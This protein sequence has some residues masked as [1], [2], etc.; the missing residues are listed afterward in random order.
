MRQRASG[1]LGALM[2]EWRH[3]TQRASLALCAPTSNSS[4]AYSVVAARPRRPSPVSPS[5]RRRAVKGPALPSDEVGVRAATWTSLCTHVPWEGWVTWVG[6]LT[7]WSPQPTNVSLQHYKGLHAPN[8]HPTQRP[9][10]QSRGLVQKRLGSYKTTL[11]LVSGVVE[12]A[13]RV[14][15]GVGEDE[16]VCVSKRPNHFFVSALSGGTA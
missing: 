4:K 11:H 5:E 9:G 8:G 12:T 13:G 10:A 1:V 15:L 7:G 16:C 6:G 2:C 3:A 14:Q